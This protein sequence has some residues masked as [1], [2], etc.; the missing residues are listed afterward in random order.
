[1]T[2][3]LNFNV[4]VRNTSQ[5]SVQFD[6]QESF[7]SVLI[8]DSSNYSVSITGLR[9]P[10]QGLETFVMDNP[11]DYYVTLYGGYDTSTTGNGVI[12]VQLPSNDALDP[13][14]GS[15][16]NGKTIMYYSPQQFI[17][18]LSR[19]IYR[20][21]RGFL[22]TYCDASATFQA[23]LLNM[24]TASNS[25]SSTVTLANTGTLNQ[26][27]IADITITISGLK[28]YTRNTNT[29]LN[30]PFQLN[31]QMPGAP[32]AIVV[33]SCSGFQNIDP[34]AG[35]NYNINLS[36]GAYSPLPSW[37]QP[38]TYL[39]SNVYAQPTTSF[40]SSFNNNGN[41]VGNWVFTIFSNM[42]FTG[43][44]TITVNI[45]ANL[46]SRFSLPPLL[47]LSSTT[48]KLSLNYQSSWAY[49]N[50]RL[51]FSPKLYSMV[52]FGQS[53][54]YY[55]SQM[56]IYEIVLPPLTS[57]NASA[58]ISATGNE[59]TTLE[60]QQSSMYNMMNISRI[61]VKSSNLRCDSEKGKSLVSDNVISDF[62]VDTDVEY[63]GDL[64]YT[65][66]AGVTPWRRYKI[67]GHASTRNI[68]LNF[69]AEYNNG[70]RRDIYIQPGLEGQA[71]LSFFKE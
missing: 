67:T 26:C 2:T 37:F 21:Y 19:T 12:T 51:G 4:T 23:N 59:I 36:E 9:I 49:S 20:A 40:I 39:S 29:P 71:R 45:S 25:L 33:W 27:N 70:L 1:M 14:F 58:P 28:L 53:Y 63:L 22:R 48:K 44:A 55:N 31:V 32:A 6:Y 18:I 57:T 13:I 54:T 65:T 47:S 43:Q 62:K 68:D 69:A 8:S 66:D 61:V 16:C 60:Q 64:T 35:A 11:A 38:Q 3:P 46:T 24:G 10:T 34:L 30:A 52:N 42:P 7:D 5:S 41:P 17:D 15:I 50:M 56:G